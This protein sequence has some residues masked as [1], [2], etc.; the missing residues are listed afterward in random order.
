MG[1]EL[2]SQLI[3]VVVLPSPLCRSIVGIPLKKKKTKNF[4]TRR[5]GHLL[6]PS[7]G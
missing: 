7:A 5:P 1:G 4:K 3:H 2:G 6:S